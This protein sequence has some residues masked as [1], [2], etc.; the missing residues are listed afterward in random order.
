MSDLDTDAI[1]TL[2]HEWLQ[3]LVMSRDPRRW[4]FYCGQPETP[5][6]IWD[7]RCGGRISRNRAEF[8]GKPRVDR[9][10]YLAALVLILI[11]GLVGIWAVTR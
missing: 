8:N 1:R 5:E 2:R 11:I 9:F 6:A 3:P 7:P 4:C 10:D